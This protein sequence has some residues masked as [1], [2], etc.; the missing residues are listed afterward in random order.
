MSVCSECEHTGDTLLLSLSSITVVA[1]MWTRIV[2]KRGLADRD[3]D[4]G[5]WGSVAR[6]SGL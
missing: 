5:K 3:V 6:A 1:Y 4:D 2:W